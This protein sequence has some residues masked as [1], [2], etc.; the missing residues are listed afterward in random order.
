ML[1]KY[2]KFLE[3][4][5]KIVLDIGLEMVFIQRTEFIPANYKTCQL[6]R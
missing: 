4:R 1:I 5:R 6:V 2:D 3:K